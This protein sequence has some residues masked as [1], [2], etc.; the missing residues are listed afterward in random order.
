MDRLIK[1]N[2]IP[3]P[4]YAY[5][6]LRAAD[7]ANRLGIPAISAL[8]FGVAGG[9]GL[10]AMQAHAET[11]GKLTGVEIK[12]YGFDT[13]GGLPPPQGYRDLPYIWQEAHF[14]MDEAALRQRLGKA[15]LVL[16]LVEDT[17]ANFATTHNP[18]PVGAIS[19]DLDYYSSSVAA[20]GIF[21]MPQ[22]KRLPRIYNYFD[23]ILSS[24]LGAVGNA[25]GVP[26]AIEEHRKAHPHHGLDPLVHL[27]FEYA[28][29][30]RWHRQIYVMSDFSH[31]RH[32]EYIVKAD[33]QLKLQG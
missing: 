27:E 9:N 11:I 31:P 23:D 21:N 32:D 10:I 15:E 1:L 18:P 5:I 2:A 16:G 26:L 20:F 14:K 29:V 30:R 7:L 24:N 6:L 3:R 22:E 13:G 28:P 25:V 8:E 19:F 12:V 33:R 4:N 17:V